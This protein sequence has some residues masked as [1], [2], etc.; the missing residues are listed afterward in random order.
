MSITIVSNEPCLVAILRYHPL[1]WSGY[2]ARNETNKGARATV[3]LNEV[4]RRSWTRGAKG[5][6]GKISRGHGPLLTPVG[7]AVAC[8]EGE[9]DEVVVGPAAEAEASRAMITRSSSTALPDLVD[10]AVLSSAIAG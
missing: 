3:L 2:A 1:A 9:V 5:G 7:A 6:Y 10:A 4:D 8:L